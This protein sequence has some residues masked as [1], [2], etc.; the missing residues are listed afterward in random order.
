VTQLSL[1]EFVND[2]QLTPAGDG[3][4]PA[5]MVPPVSDR[6]PNH[7]PGYVV[8]FIHLHERDF[9]APAS[10]FMRGLGHHYGVELHNFAPNAISRA[11]SFVAICEGFWGVP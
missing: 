10:R 11:A 3:P 5:W 7:P 6:E 1:E 2:G 8:S 4:R 9:N